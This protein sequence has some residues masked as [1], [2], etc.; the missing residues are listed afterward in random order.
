[1]DT[2]AWEPR[3][4]SVRSTVL[5]GTSRGDSPVPGFLGDP[6]T[7]PSSGGAQRRLRRPEPTLLFALPFLGLDR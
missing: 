4:A 7:R 1:M 3:E 2:Q 6:A 5:L